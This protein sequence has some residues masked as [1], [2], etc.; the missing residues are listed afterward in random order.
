MWPSQSVV[1]KPPRMEWMMSSL[2]ACKSCNSPLFCSSSAPFRRSVCARTTRKIGHGHECKEIAEDP[3]LQSACARAGQRGPREACRRNTS[4]TIPPSK[5]KAEPCREE[6]AFA[7]EQNAG[8][9]DGQ[10]IK[11]NEVAFVPACKVHQPGDHAQVA[12]HFDRREPA[13]L[14]HPARQYRVQESQRVPED[15]QRGERLRRTAAAGQ[16][17][18]GT[19]RWRAGAK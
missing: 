12:D 6:R 10:Q 8:D 4:S 1:S 17:A 14:F 13:R 15:D 18:R 7:R 5:H 16:A 19:E 9:D 3:G 2:K 11:R